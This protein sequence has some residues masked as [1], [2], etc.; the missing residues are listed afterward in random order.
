MN[1]IWKK[2]SSSLRQLEL[3]W[4][5]NINQTHDLWCHCEDPTTHLLYC[6]NKF[7]T[8]QKP[9]IDIKNIRCLLT[10]KPTTPAEDTTEKDD[11]EFLEGE[12]EMLFKEK[13]K[14]ENTEDDVTR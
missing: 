3:G 13:E 12:L 6:I 1:P 9:L 10:G 14:P 11:P 4:I 5:N 8:V 2:P 7:S